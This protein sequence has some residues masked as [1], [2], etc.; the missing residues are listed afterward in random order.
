[1]GFK[2]SSVTQDT[3]SGVAPGVE[4]LLFIVYWPVICDTLRHV[5]TCCVW[6]SCLRSLDTAEESTWILFCWIEPAT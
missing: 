6:W 2:F 4:S 5:L 3:D 1:M